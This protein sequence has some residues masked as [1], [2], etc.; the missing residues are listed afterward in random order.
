M[1]D[2]VAV[3]RIGRSVNEGEASQISNYTK[4]PF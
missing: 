1:M 2:N 4:S 3:E